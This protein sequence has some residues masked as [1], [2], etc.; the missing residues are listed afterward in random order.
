M[1]HQE[2]LFWSGGWRGGREGILYVL[3]GFFFAS[4]MG[5]VTCWGRQA[6]AKL[7]FELVCVK[8]DG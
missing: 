4:G 3:T 5:G 6:V 7:D 1:A 8:P 2:G